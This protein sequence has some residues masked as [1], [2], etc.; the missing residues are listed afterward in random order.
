M[1]LPIFTEVEKKEEHFQKLE[2]CVYGSKKPWQRMRL[3]IF[4]DR[5]YRCI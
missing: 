5:R 1:S 4:Y 3:Q 2:D